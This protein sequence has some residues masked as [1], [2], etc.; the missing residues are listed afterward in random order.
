MFRSGFD[1]TFFAVGMVLTFG[2]G[3]GV[4]GCGPQNLKPPKCG[5]SDTQA[6]TVGR[7]AIKKL[8]LSVF[9]GGALFGH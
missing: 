7:F 5:L 4:H 2:V 3:I 6:L 8:Q 1:R 9:M